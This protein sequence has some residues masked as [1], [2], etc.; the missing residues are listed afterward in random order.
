MKIFLRAITVTALLGLVPQYAKAETV[1]WDMANEY[2]DRSIHAEGDK[3]FAKL[4]K[5]KTGG[6]VEITLH[7]GASLGF[8]SKDQLEAVADGAIPL[9]D[10]FTGPLAG[11]D[12]IFQLSGLPFLTQSFD[13]ARV[14]FE[15]GK[16]RYQEVLKK[17]NQTLLWATPWPPAGIWAKQNVPD[18]AGLQG[19]KIRTYDK[20]GT[21]T[22]TEAGASPVQLSWADVVPQL[23]TGGINAVLTS[24]EAGLSGNFQDLL[25]HYVPIA[26]GTP[27]NIA[28]IN[29]D[30]LAKLTEKQRA[31]VLEAAAEVSAHQW[32]IVG[33]RVKSNFERATKAGVTVHESVDPALMKHLQK[34]GEA[35]VKAWLEQAGK[36]GEEILAAYRSKVAN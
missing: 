11:V 30:A 5:E 8:R 23:T 10:T 3:L 29:N 2:G 33:P 7:F 6:S 36:T 21:I 4:V 16:A 26:I 25:S 35:A 19:L 12:P 28:T 24:A 14:L 27:L 18:V 31:A 9:A 32:K 1:R 34:S 15:V 20:L 13:D 22:L 17:Y